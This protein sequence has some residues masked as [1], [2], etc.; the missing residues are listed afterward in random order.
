M[1]FFE[2]E[3]QVHHPSSS[4]RWYSNSLGDNPFHCNIRHKYTRIFLAPYALVDQNCTY[5]WA[6]IQIF[7]QN[8]R[9]RSF[10]HRHILISPAYLP[11]AAQRGALVQIGVTWIRPTSISGFHEPFSTTLLTTTM[12]DSP[13]WATKANPLNEPFG[14]KQW[15]CPMLLFPY[16]LAA[17]SGRS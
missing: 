4:Q 9:K 5:K 1:S 2:R 12:A 17:H 16:W 3:E 13:N 8:L 6:S 15:T 14:Q 7:V 11:V 10:M